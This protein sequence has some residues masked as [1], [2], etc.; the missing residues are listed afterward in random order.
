MTWAEAIAEAVKQV[1]NASW[2]V[3]KAAAK[4][5]MA[6]ANGGK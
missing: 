3:V 2:T 5:I 4:A 6:T 1:G